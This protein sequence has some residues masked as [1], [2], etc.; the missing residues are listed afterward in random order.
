MHSTGE[1]TRLLRRIQA[2]HNDAMDELIPL[3]YRELRSV[4]GRFFSS[5]RPGHT[6]QPTAL[7][8][9]VYFRLVGKSE[10]RCENRE[11]FFALAAQMMRRILVD[12]AR[13]HRALKRGGLQPVIEFDESLAISHER[14]ADVVIVDEL[15]TKLAKIDADVARLVELRFFGGLSVKETA[16]VMGT[17]VSTVKREWSFARAWFLKEMART[18]SHDAGAVAA[19]WDLFEAARTLETPAREH[20][21]RN[22]CGGDHELQSEVLEMLEAD[23]SPATFFDSPL[24]DSY[25]TFTT[26]TNGNDDIFEDRVIG[27]YH[28]IRRIGRGGMGAV[29]LAEQTNGFRKLVAFKLMQSGPDQEQLVRRFHNERQTL[30]VLDHPNIVRLL[31]GGTTPE[32]CPYLVMDYVDGQTIDNYCDARKLGIRERLQL[33]REVC[34]AVQYAHQNLIVHR[35][36][37]PANIL[38]TS[39][40]IPKLLDFGVARLLK[41]EYLAM[42]AGLTRTMTQP[43]TPEYASP[44]QI[45]GLP[46]TTA[47][48][49]YS[50]GVV[51]FRLLTG[52]LPYVLQSRSAGELETAICELG[53]QMPSS[54]L[55]GHVERQYTHYQFCGDLDNI[56]SMTLRKEPQRRYASVD[57]LSDDL[58]RH[59]DGMPVVARKPTFRYRAQK[60]TRHAASVTAAA[61]AVLILALTTI[62]ALHNSRVAVRQQLRAEHRFEDLR[63]LASFVIFEFDDAIRSGP[64]EARRRLIPKALEYLDGLA[65]EPGATAAL[66]VELANAYLR[67]G[68]LQGNLYDAIPVILREQGRATGKLWSLPEALEM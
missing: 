44:E 25:S 40:G 11:H 52:Q 57:Q 47:S 61:V 37:K 18:D 20:Y 3:V 32:G 30:A 65:N 13:R 42:N 43:H 41:P 4:A 21:V 29:Y 12:H 38:V 15:L 68:D 14:L 5:E 22:K 58:R 63:Q 2:G 8:H 10:E 16:T 17:S 23:S 67:V 64:T 53:P 51:L 6:L 60:S 27:H 24:L 45:K 62:L 54:Q 28:L 31:D 49:I 46:I 26:D 19:G 50:L 59:L 35:D 66:Q 55:C 1:V 36:L 39:D 34:G 56:V 48:D 33:F 7:V 9:E